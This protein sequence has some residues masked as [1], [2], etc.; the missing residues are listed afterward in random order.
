[1]YEKLL[2]IILFVYGIMEKIGRTNLPDILGFWRE[3]ILNDSLRESFSYFGLYSKMLSV[4]KKFVPEYV[5]F[6]SDKN[7]YFLY[8]EPIENKSDKIIVWVH[9]G[10]WNAGT[11]KYFDF[12]GQCAANEGYRFISLGYRLSPKNKYPC[13]IQDVSEGF[14]AAMKFL[15]EKEI[16]ASKIIVSGPSAGA[17]LS[18][19]LCYCKSVQEQYN[20]DVSNVIGF[21]GVGGPYSFQV[22]TTMSV[23]ILLNQLFSKDYD[24]SRGE[25]CTLMGKSSIPMLLI[26][27]KH[28][29][30]I[31]FS[32]AERFYEKAKSVG[33]EC[34]LYEVVDKKNTHSWYTAGMF[35][36]TREENKGLD[37]FFSWIEMI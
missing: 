13:Q 17:H 30:L 2:L 20:T 10:G 37:K 25:P 14:N 24:R 12:V 26:Q 5:S 33:N 31:D 3:Y 21:I 28:D 29:G 4:K 1:M 32:C 9:G 27:S 34:E 8:Y 18:S 19:I 35:L 11:P 22:K 15:N 23:K 7:Q 36:E 16:D 6:G